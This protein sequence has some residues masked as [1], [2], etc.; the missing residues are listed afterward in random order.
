MGKQKKFQ[1]TNQYMYIYWK[2]P[3]LSQ[4][5]VTSKVLILKGFHTHKRI[6]IKSEAKLSNRGW[7]SASSD[8]VN[9]DFC[10]G[11]ETRN[12]R[13]KQNCLVVEGYISTFIYTNE[14]LSNCLW[15][16]KWWFTKFSLKFFTW[17]KII[18]CSSMNQYSCSTNGY[19][20]VIG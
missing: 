2:A 11:H 1:T 13:T 15:L 7:Q 10:R 20:W 8:L 14:K 5:D 18:H 3:V 6:H 12:K 16:N 4:I 17:L 9:H 19:L